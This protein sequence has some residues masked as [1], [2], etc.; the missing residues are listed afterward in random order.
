MAAPA[1]SRTYVVNDPTR[2]RGCTPEGASGPNFEVDHLF[3]GDELAVAGINALAGLDFTCK[4]KTAQEQAERPNRL[5][6]REVAVPA[7]ARAIAEMIGRVAVSE[8]LSDEAGRPKRTYP[9]AWRRSAQ[10]AGEPAW[11][12][13]DKRDELVSHRM[14]VT[15]DAIAVKLSL[16]TSVA[17]AMNLFSLCVLGAYD[18][19]LA[20]LPDDDPD[21]MWRKGR[22]G[23][24]EQRPQRVVELL[25][26]VPIYN[27]LVKVGRLKQ[28]LTDTERSY[29]LALFIDA[30]A[31]AT[32]HPLIFRENVFGQYA[33][34]HGD[35]A[36]AGAPYRKLDDD[37]LPRI[38]DLP[39]LNVSERVLDDAERQLRQ[40]LTERERVFDKEREKSPRR[41]SFCVGRGN[42]VDPATM[43]VRKFA[44]DDHTFVCFKAIDPPTDADGNILRL[45]PKV[46][47]MPDVH[48]VEH[49]YSMEGFIDTIMP[50]DDAKDAFW[51]AMGCAIFHDLPWHAAVIFCG[52]GGVGKSTTLDMIRNMYGKD[53]VQY[54]GQLSLED[55]SNPFYVAT[56]R[57]IGLNASDESDGNFIR[58]V[59]P[60]KALLGGGVII[61][62]PIYGHPFPFT[63]EHI[64]FFFAMNEPPR[65]VDHSGAFRRRFFCLRFPERVTLD[66]LAVTDRTPGI[67]ALKNDAESLTWLFCETLFHMR[68]M[69]GESLF[70]GTFSGF[71]QN[72]YTNRSWDRYVSSSNASVR[73]VSD[74]M[75][76]DDYAHDLFH[77]PTIPVDLLFKLACCHRDSDFE[78]SKFPGKTEFNADIKDYLS[79]G[80]GKSMPYVRLY[81]VKTKQACAINTKA[82]WVPPT[83]PAS[84]IARVA[85]EN[86]RDLP[87]F[88]AID[89]YSGRSGLVL[90]AG[91]TV[92]HRRPPTT[93]CGPWMRRDLFDHYVSTSETPA[94][95][96]AR[97]WDPSCSLL[98]EMGLEDYSPE[99]LAHYQEGLAGKYGLED[100]GWLYRGG[101]GEDPDG[102]DGDG[103]PA[104]PDAPE[105]VAVADDEA[106]ERLHQVAAESFDRLGVTV[107]SDMEGR[108]IPISELSEREWVACGRP[109]TVVLRDVCY[110]DDDGS[111]VRSE[112]WQVADTWV[113]APSGDGTVTA[114]ASF[115]T[116]ARDVDAAAAARGLQARLPRVSE[117]LCG[118]PREPHACLGALVRMGSGLAEPP[119]RL[120]AS[121]DDP[122]L[123]LD[124]GPQAVP[125][126]PAPRLEG[127]TQDDKET[128]HVGQPDSELPVQEGGECQ[129]QAQGEA[130]QAAGR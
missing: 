13:A 54:T 11:D 68:E 124:L 29:A 99:A 100:A 125:D 90:G 42:V 114:V 74:M 121:D 22:G 111:P 9:G 43:R 15:W 96:I 2:T 48:G 71:R 26:Y 33:G 112:T 115:V 23:E 72:D 122:Y 47:R 19:G 106:V 76:T 25:G 20:L 58:H 103:G 46:I 75:A 73:V 60:L 45:P 5:P 12:P 7:I 3:S 53:F 35:D 82:W 31:K 87:T 104:A 130:A 109:D 39:E 126:D 52:T 120:G 108:D 17:S 80:H 78:Q 69:F 128:D 21:V 34:H 85:D 28:D 79:R 94:Q 65:F 66:G 84:V 40:A 118:T 102:P 81:N 116:P 50:T 44:E 62:R 57:G 1:A 67:D 86:V 30:V 41:L 97:G 24:T 49:D 32:G 101:D 59:A 64:S 6:S 61:V 117:F 107:H 14:R 55:L 113:D 91:T 36:E 10:V 63:D 89:R 18:C 119:R 92:S 88:N 70:D 83:D 56:L 93:M 105:A 4:R 37:E 51:Q 16:G 98:P 77:L 127:T 27:N 129:A 95:C 110:V 123:Y 38:L 8:N